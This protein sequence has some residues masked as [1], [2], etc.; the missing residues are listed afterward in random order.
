MT[1]HRNLKAAIRRFMAEHEVSYT[2]ARRLMGLDVL[3]FNFTD[4]A[5]VE[6]DVQI[7]GNRLE[8]RW[9]MPDGQ[10][11]GRETHLSHLFNVGIWPHPFSP[12]FTVDGS[13]EGYKRSL[14]AAGNVAR[15]RTWAAKHVKSPATL[16]QD[17][18]DF[19][20][21]LAQPGDW[22]YTVL[23]E[24]ASTAVVHVMR[25]PTEGPG[26]TQPH[27]VL[28]WYEARMKTMDELFERLVR[29][30]MS[31]RA[32]VRFLET[33]AISGISLEDAIAQHRTWVRDWRDHPLSQA[34]E[35]FAWRAVEHCEL[36]DTT[37]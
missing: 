33:G 11:D 1:A 37:V 22:L 35:N 5:G 19:I 27:A 23:D 18:V 36:L 31:G 29:A 24:V 7:R 8:L 16:S 3:T 15:V 20:S 28:A 2:E 25:L 13:M 4:A 6:V 30:E 26:G 34:V 17:D 21:R 10:E 9:L 12:A 32:G 14:L